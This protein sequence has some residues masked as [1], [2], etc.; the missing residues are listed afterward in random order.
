MPR[1]TEFRRPTGYRAFLTIWSGQ[2]LSAVGTRMTNFA[3]SVWLWDRTGSAFALSLMLLAAF[4]STLLVSPFVGGLVDRLPRRATIIISDAGSTFTTLALALLFALGHAQVW[5]L[6]AVNLL[7]GGF[8]AF[9]GPA[10]G[11]AISSML[12]QAQYPRANALMSMI[13]SLPSLLAPSFASALIAFAGVKAILFLDSG[14]YLLAIGAVLVT[15]LPARTPSPADHEQAASG[16]WADAAFG[17]RYI[18]RRRPLIWFEG[19]IFAVGVLAASGYAMLNPLVLAR[20]GNSN[21]VLAAVMTTAAVGGVVGASTLTALKDTPHKIRRFLLATLVFSI[22]GRILIGVGDTVV[23][24]SVAMFV[25]H[26][27]L[28]FMDGYTNAVWQERVDPAV[29]GRVFA[30]RGFI[31]NLTIPVGLLIAGPLATYVFEPAMR[32]GHSLARAFEPLVGTGPG[33]GMALICVGV[34]VIGILTVAFSFAVRP[35]R[36]IE[37]L[38]PRLPAPAAQ[39]ADQPAAEAAQPAES[40]IETAAQSA[41]SVG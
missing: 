27:C 16:F 26:L 14:S 19:L 8:L 12:E 6:Y 41:A 11:A 10:F 28:P 1:F 5:E 15:T 38:I 32:P 36:E 3:L 33:A 25:T 23:L 29:Q 13:R 24:W 21:G 31:E 7:T 30:A 18:L 9:Q 37:T 39:D 34:G 17:F 4:G 20:S 22:L 40:A 2:I 35:L